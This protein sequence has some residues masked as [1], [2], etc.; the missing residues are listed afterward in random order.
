L[1]NNAGMRKP[2][3]AEANYIKTSL[4]LPPELR[5]HLIEAGKEKGRTMNAEILSRL[6]AAPFHDRLDRLEKDV[7]QIKAILIELRDR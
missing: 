4:R 2:E 6:K 3:D 1:A 7:A 5:D